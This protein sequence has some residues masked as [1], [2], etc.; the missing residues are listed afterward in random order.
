MYWGVALDV[1][2]R[3]PVV[4]LPKL[5]AVCP[6]KKGDRKK[7]DKCRTCRWK[8]TGWGEKKEK[9]AAIKGSS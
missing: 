1:G 7:G 2:K 8:A 9:K 6:G 3:Q 5:C 4:I